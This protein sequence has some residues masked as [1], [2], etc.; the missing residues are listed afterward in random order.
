MEI[1]KENYQKLTLIFSSIQD[2]DQLKRTQ[3]EQEL[4]KIETQNGYVLLLMSF[5][6]NREINSSLQLQA[7][8]TFKN[9]IKREWKPTM[10]QS[11]LQKEDREKVKENL[12]NLMLFTKG[13][14]RNQLSDA[15]LTISNH[16]FF[17]EW[18]NLIEVQYF[19]IK[20][21]WL[22]QK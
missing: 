4:N 19:F 3:A 17:R 10:K 21:R 14:I 8:I 6:A 11:F 1:N 5:I 12:L 13:N 22:Y 20:F 7:A 15:L 16:D 18:E 9:F 2:S